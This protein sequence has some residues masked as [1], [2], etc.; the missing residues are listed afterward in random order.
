M[1]LVCEWLFQQRSDVTKPEV[2]VSPLIHIKKRKCSRNCIYTCSYV[3]DF[4][5]IIIY[6]T[7][8]V[9]VCSSLHDKITWLRFENGSDTWYYSLL[10]WNILL[11][12]ILKIWEWYFDISILRV[13]LWYLNLPLFQVKDLM[14]T[15]TEFAREN[16][17][18]TIMLISYDNDSLIFDMY[19]MIKVISRYY[20]SNYHPNIKKISQY[21]FSN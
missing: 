14:A 5:I 15:I 18:A 4:D 10:F 9:S 21:Q 6:Q 13:I 7:I 11:H 19:I 8:T 1:T 20:H 3:E 17:W 2:T 12:A 16:Y